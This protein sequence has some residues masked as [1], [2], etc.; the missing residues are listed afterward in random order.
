MMIL[1]TRPLAAR[2]GACYFGR[3]PGFF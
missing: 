1:I 2:T 3:P